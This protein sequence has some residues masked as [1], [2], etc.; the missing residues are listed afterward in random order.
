MNSPQPH[1]PSPIGIQYY[2]V[3]SSAQKNHIR[4]HSPP[5][6]RLQILILIQNTNL[7]YF[8]IF[9]LI[10]KPLAQRMPKSAYLKN[11]SAYSH[12]SLPHPTLDTRLC[13]LAFQSRVYGKVKDFEGEEKVIQV[14]KQTKQKQDKKHFK[15]FGAGSRLTC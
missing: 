15:N 6:P 13:P 10:H 4:L 14:Y 5:T 2:T 7:P 3:N 8:L 1:S 11:L 12:E 9:S